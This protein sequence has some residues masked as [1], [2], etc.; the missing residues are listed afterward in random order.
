M[1]TLAM[2]F[3]QKPLPSGRIIFLT[4]LYLS[5]ACSLSKKPAESPKTYT[6]TSAHLQE[7]A[8]V[9][10]PLAL[11]NPPLPKIDAED[12][13]AKAPLVRDHQEGKLHLM[14]IDP[15]LTDKNVDHAEMEIC[16]DGGNKNCEVYEFIDVLE[17]F[18]SPYKGL[19]KIKTRFCVYQARA[20]DAQ[21][22]CSAWSKTLFFKQAVNNKEYHNKLLDIYA[23][24]NKLKKIFLTAQTHVQ[25]FIESCSTCEQDKVQGWRSLLDVDPELAKEFISNDEILDY[26]DSHLKKEG[27][28]SNSLEEEQKSQAIFWALLAKMITEHGHRQSFLHWKNKIDLENL[29]SIQ[30]KVE[31]SIEIDTH[32]SKKDMA[33]YKELLHKQENLKKEIDRILK[34]RRSHEL[35]QVRTMMLMSRRVTSLIKI[36]LNIKNPLAS[37]SIGIL[38]SSLTGLLPYSDGGLHLSENPWQ[39]LYKDL[40]NSYVEARTLIRERNR[41]IDSLP[42]DLIDEIDE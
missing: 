36:R 2:R 13:K 33:R 23:Y 9:E 39:L 3:I 30:N 22:P 5:S 11:I 19:L 42:L 16:E 7:T 25:N 21:N 35:A 31:Q 40:S 28:P 27:I 32:L 10:K 24:K 17:R 4:M 41:E 14:H 37:I 29:Q 34:I 38:I 20:K 6:P 1:A 8:P 26:I 12:I 15:L 18:P